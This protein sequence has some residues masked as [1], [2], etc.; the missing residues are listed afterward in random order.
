[1]AGKEKTEEREGWPEREKEMKRGRSGSK[2]KKIGER[3][4]QPERES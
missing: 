2:K 4:G 1:M 3:E